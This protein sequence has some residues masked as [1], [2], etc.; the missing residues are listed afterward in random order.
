MNE[1][2]KLFITFAI[3]RMQKAAAYEANGQHE[4]AA[5]YRAKAIAYLDCALQQ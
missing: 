1:M 4:A 2:F 3:E 5:R